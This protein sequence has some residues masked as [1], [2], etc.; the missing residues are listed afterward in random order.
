MGKNPIQTTTLTI[1][2]QSHNPIMH[3]HGNKMLENAMHDHMI[4]IRSKPNPKFFT[5]LQKPNLPKQKLKPRSTCMK[6]MKDEEKKI[7]RTHTNELKLGFGQ[8]LEGMKDFGEK[9]RFGSREKRERSKCL[10]EK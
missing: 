9:M 10:S 2:N 6:C 1:Y 3:E 4:T 7:F 5:K 8:N